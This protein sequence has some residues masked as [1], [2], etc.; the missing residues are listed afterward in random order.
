MGM[1]DRSDDQDP[2]IYGVAT[3]TLCGSEEEGSLLRLS[4]GMQFANEDDFFNEEYWPDYDGPDF[5]RNSLFGSAEWMVNRH[6]TLMAEIQEAHDDASVLNFGGR[7]SPCDS[8]AVDVFLL[9]DETK[10]DYD[11]AIGISGLIPFEADNVFADEDRTESHDSSAPS[12]FGDTGMILMPNALVAP[13]H[14]AT[15]TYHL[16]N[17]GIGDGNDIGAWSNAGVRVGTTDR[18]EIYAGLLTF[19]DEPFETGAEE[20]EDHLVFHA[21]AQPLREPDNW[22]NVAVGV[23]N[24]GLAEVGDGDQEPSGYVVATKTIC[25]SGDEDDPSFLRATAGLLLANDDGLLNEEYFP[26]DDGDYDDDSLFAGVE[27]RACQKLTVLG[28]IIEVGDDD[29]AFNFG[30]RLHPFDRLTVD[31]FLVEDVENSDHEFGWGA[32]YRIPF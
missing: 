21:K 20:E 32:S 1:D 7:F 6:I 29:T 13:R 8:V 5:D 9:E 18:L 27:W 19:E 4:L 23:R 17:D 15:P 14:T 16:I 26:S 28:E 31:A 25:A 22:C 2:T 30:A 24:V 10:D 11:M 3:K 12:H